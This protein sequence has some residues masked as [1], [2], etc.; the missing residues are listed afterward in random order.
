VSFDVAADAYD[1]FMGRYSRPLAP[2][3]ADLACVRAGQRALDVGCGPGALTSELV[4]RL[5]ADAVA[6]V[7]PSEPFVQAARRRHHGVDVAVAAAEDLPFGDGSFDV[8]LAQLVVPFMSEPVAGL[9]E[10]RRVTTSGGIVAA[11]VWD[12][13]GG[14]A[15]QSAFWQA[16]RELD[17]GA[18]DESEQ[19]GAREGQLAE[20]FQAAGLGD[21]EDD[22]L[23]VRLEH[24]SFEE[25]WQPFTI[26]V[27]PVGTYVAG[28]DAVACAELRERCRLLL[29]DAPFTLTARAW[30]ARG[31]A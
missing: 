28:L 21:V 29:R 11:C 5:G 17:P 14:Q 3:L 30:T 26:G 13:A 9:A 6:A 1:R 4:A 12:H 7:D 10:M 20:L 16:V 25:W 2:Q 23:Y 22:A 31:R 8:A 19:P 15:P 27:G 24:A 18:R